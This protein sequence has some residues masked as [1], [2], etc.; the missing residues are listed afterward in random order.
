MLASF[1][2]EGLELTLTTLGSKFNLNCIFLSKK[3]FTSLQR[4]KKMW[5]FF[6]TQR[7]EQYTSS[8]GSFPGLVPRHHKNRTIIISLLQFFAIFF[9][10]FMN[11][12]IL[13]PRITHT[14]LQGRAELLD[15]LAMKF[16]HKIA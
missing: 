16:F 6:V 10:S 2:D 12:L 1:D 5:S 14:I 8:S 9:K 7:D 3:L 15:P 11:H 13:L 4:K